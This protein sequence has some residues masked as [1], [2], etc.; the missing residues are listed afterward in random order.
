MMSDDSN[1]EPS[2]NRRN[3][4]KAA[5]AT[6]ASSGLCEFAEA[7]FAAEPVEASIEGFTGQL[8]YQAGDKVSLHVSTGA[9]R[10]SVEVARLG[11]S[12]DVVLTAGNV[13]GTRHPTPSDASSQGCR[14]PA[15]LE[16]P[17]QP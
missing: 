8:S 17:V 14:W 7:A 1:R 5:A 4:L 2:L 6:A 11:A 15:T 3:L 9:A 10:F 12:R 16:I 13:A